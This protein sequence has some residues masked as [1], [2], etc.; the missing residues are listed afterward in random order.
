[1]QSGRTALLIATRQGHVTAVQILLEKHA[2]SNL[3][4]EVILHVLNTM[5]G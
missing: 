4:D 3:C 2:D 5:Y 1:M